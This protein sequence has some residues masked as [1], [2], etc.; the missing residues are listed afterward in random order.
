[1]EFDFTLDIITHALEKSK[2][3]DLWE[4]YKLQYPQMNKENYF[5]FTEYKD[6]QMGHSFKKHSQ[7][8]YEEIEAEMQKVENAFS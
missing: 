7:I 8:S 6:D 4:N 3:K 5:S 1:M 2:E